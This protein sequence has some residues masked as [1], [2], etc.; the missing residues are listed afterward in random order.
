MGDLPFAH[1]LV[2]LTAVLALAAAFELWF[3]GHRAGRYREYLFLLGLGLL[4][5][6]FGAVLDQITSSLSPDYFTFFKGIAP[7]PGFRAAVTALGFEAGFLAGVL[8]AAAWLVT[9]NP[10]SD[11]PQLAYGELLGML[12]TPIVHALVGGLVL[13]VL[14]WALASKCDFVPGMPV[15]SG[16]RGLLLTLGGH[17]GLYL[18]ALVGTVRV[19][20]RIRRRRARLASQIRCFT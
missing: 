4:G 11:R 2:F 10:R 18:G 14:V 12:G 19:V 9:N 6:T 1:R 3:R 15:S 13:A 20:L 7:G 5:G 16:Q 8:I 17:A